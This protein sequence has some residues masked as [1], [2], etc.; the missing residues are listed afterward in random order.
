MPI[1]LTHRRWVGLLAIL[2]LLTG[3]TIPAA[4][5]Q[6][7]SWEL[8]A[9][10]PG[11][12]RVAMMAAAHTTFAAGCPQLGEFEAGAVAALIGTGQSVTVGGAGTIIAAM[13][14]AWRMPA[15]ASYQTTKE[16]PAALSPREAIAIQH[17][18]QREDAAVP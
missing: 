6:A 16:A 15:I 11:C 3:V 10:E 1:E 14:L 12:G 18:Q 13:L 9:G 7:G 5:A 4:E 17:E 8:F 2:L